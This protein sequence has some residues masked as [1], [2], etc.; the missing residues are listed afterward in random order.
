MPSERIQRQIE[1]FLDETE[2]AVAERAWDDVRQLSACVLSID[3]TNADALAFLAMA[4][5]DAE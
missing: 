5:A 3:A 4:D 2:A 1:R